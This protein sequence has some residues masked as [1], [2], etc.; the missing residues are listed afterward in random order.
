MKA[1]VGQILI[2]Q[3]LP[4]DLRDYSRVLDKK[5][6]ADLMDKLAT[7]GDMDLY[8][9][10]VQALYKVGEMS[11]RSTAP[12]LS[13]ASLKTPPKT[14]AMRQALRTK[15]DEIAQR[16]DLTPEQRDRVIIDV[17]GQAIPAIEKTLYEES[18]QQGN[19]FAIQVLSGSR[20]GPA[21]LR[22]LLAGD[23]LVSDHR[24]R[25]IA[26][27]ILKSY[28][29][30][31][32]PAEY[33]AGSYGSRK[34]TISTKLSTAKTGY[35]GKQLVQAAHREV[36]SEADCG[37]DRG[38]PV[39]PGDADNLGAVL[40]QDYGDVKAGTIIDSKVLKRMQAFGEDDNNP[41]HVMVRS[42]LT[43]RAGHGL[44]S[45]CVGIRERGTL[46][47][48]GDNVGITAAQS[49]AERMSQ[50]ALSQKHS[51]GRHSGVTSSIPTGYDLINQI[52]QAP[53][54]FKAAAAIA[55]LDGTVGAISKAPQ[56]GQYITIGEDR[57][58]V[59]EGFEISVKPGDR[60]EAG[61]IM[62]EGVANPAELVRHR[63]MGAGRL[64][65]V[66]QFQKAFKDSG[67]KAGRRNIEILARGLVNHV[68][69]TELDGIDD[70]LPDDI[71]EYGAIEAKYQPRYGF[72]KTKPSDA[73]GNFLERPVAQYS[74]G[75][76]ITPRVAQELKKIGVGDITVHKDP[77]PFEPEFIRGME[78]SSVSPDWQIRMG[79][80]YLERGL[81]EAVHRGRG[82]DATSTS[83]I[84]A[85]ARGKGFAEN[86]KETGKY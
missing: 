53:K 58:Y 47:A 1:T 8:R 66:R 4:E 18:L 50:G 59:P 26:M 65:F 42:P 45:K 62:S 57:H 13:I 85:L 61:D 30:G 67:I 41:Q 21:D 78:Q 28:S 16:R 10:V 55:Q 25:P 34:G 6:A 86:L 79:G 7:R 5:G 75:T 64:E 36:I 31:L 49:L 82:T 2:N 71:M 15:I 23:M 17:T 20:G 76:R 27:P 77:P 33:W 68:R 37:T 44:C 40:Q 3:M 48:I 54:T 46:P 35:L 51:G 80:S 52:V 72:R 83:Y 70:A 74:I 12:S 63:G 14:K 84:P 19:P 24:D 69:A 38:I 29:E 32:D 60:V 9:D 73:I 43:C 39:E 56:G 81:L 11:N 22:S